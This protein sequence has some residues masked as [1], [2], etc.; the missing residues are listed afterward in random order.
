MND[1]FDY[2]IFATE[3]M[4]VLICV[5]L[6]Y[7]SIKETSGRTTRGNMYIVMVLTNI[8][9][10][11]SD[12]LLTATDGSPN[13]PVTR[14]ISAAIAVLLALVLV[15]QF[16]IYLTLYIRERHPVPS[17]VSRPVMIYNTFSLL[18]VLVISLT[19][20]IFT[21]ED[22][23]YTQGALY[24]VY[25][26]TNVFSL[27]ISIV[28]VITYRKELGGHDSV[29]AYL[30]IA[31]PAVSA[32]VSIFV[33]GWSFAYTSS[34]LS[35]FILYVTIQSEHTNKLEQEK[36]ISLYYATHDELTELYSRRAYIDKAEALAKTEAWAGI[37]FC[38]VNGLKYTNDNYGHKAGD[39]L[40]IRF[41]GVLSSQFRKEEVFR[42]SG[43]EFVVLMSDIK[44]DV[45]GQRVQKLETALEAD[46]SP[47]ASIGT[48]YGKCCDIKQSIQTAEEMMYEQKTEFHKNHPEMKR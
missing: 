10:L 11:V 4:S 32:I 12:A 27:L 17:S 36:Q 13:L 29:V 21:F 42:I 33:E 19:G 47:I 43:D 25:V 38:D 41:A 3:V 9:A 39:D 23:I 24:D 44:E 20:K 31:I 30:Y 26:I 28:L 14:N 16:T 15:G 7:V 46:E 22:G 5:V 34:T 6:L 37:I 45:F 2:A 8:V 18:V 1:P 40:L 48:S 35:L